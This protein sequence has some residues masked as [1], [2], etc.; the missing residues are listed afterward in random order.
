MV[1][2]RGW[3]EDVRRRRWRGNGERIT[4]G[5]H[6]GN[7]GRCVTGEWREDSQVLFHRIYIEKINILPMAKNKK[8]DNNHLVVLCTV[9]DRYV[10]HL[11]MPPESSTT[12][13]LLYKSTTVSG[14]LIKGS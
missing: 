13:V 11:A 3:R 5:G 8:T 1:T 14:V 6:R 10:G 9:K 2:E 12:A 4:G 7:G